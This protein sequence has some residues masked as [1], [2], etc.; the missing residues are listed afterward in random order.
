MTD[1]RSSDLAVA[2]DKI[3]LYLLNVGH[4]EG[5]AKARF[6][7]ARGF[8]PISTGPFVEALLDHAR[9]GHLVS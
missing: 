6:F 9:P 1:G 8:D 5:G 2:E 4:A 7:I 3:R